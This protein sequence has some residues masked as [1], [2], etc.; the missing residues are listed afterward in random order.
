MFMR[1]NLALIDDEFRE[2]NNDISKVMHICITWSAKFDFIHSNITK[3]DPLAVNYRMVN[4][5]GLNASKKTE[6]RL[7]SHIKVSFQHITE[8]K[9]LEMRGIDPRSSR[10]LSGRS[11]I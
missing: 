11:T 5:S 10:M 9:I 1:M 8:I 7:G 2:L 3:Y 4:S 6:V